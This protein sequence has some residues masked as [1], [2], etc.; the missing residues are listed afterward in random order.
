LLIF[1]ITTRTDVCGINYSHI[2]ANFKNIWDI[3]NIFHNYSVSYS[4]NSKFLHEKKLF[5]SLS[6]VWLA[7]HVY[8]ERCVYI[9][10]D[11]ISLVYV[12]HWA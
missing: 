3:L 10:C 9:W 2:F 7:S 8:Y 4:Q 1:T 6:T 11:V 12:F 5:Y